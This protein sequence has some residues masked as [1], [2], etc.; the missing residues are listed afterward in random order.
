MQRFVDTASAGPLTGPA[1][2]MSKRNG[3]VQ[4]SVKTAS[5]AHTFLKDEERQETSAIFQ[6]KEKLVTHPVVIESTRSSKH[7]T[8]HGVESWRANAQCNV[9]DSCLYT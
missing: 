3:L 2:K 7:Q 8:K 4:I 6:L 1:E 9:K 5:G